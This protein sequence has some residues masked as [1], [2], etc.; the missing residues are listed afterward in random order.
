GKI[1]RHLDRDDMVANTIGTFCSTTVHCAQCHNHKFDPITQ[2]DYYAL[3]A[4]FAAVDRTERKY[5]ADDTLNARFTMLT[6]QQR[7]ADAAIA[8]AEEP[9]RKKA[10]AKFV[11]LTRR[12]DGASKAAAKKLGNTS[13]DYG[14]HSAI[15]PKQDAVKWV[16]V[17]LGRRVPIDHIT[18]LPCYDDFNSIGAGFGFPVRFKVEASDD[19]EFKAGVTL[20]W[21]RHDATF[22]NDFRNPGLQ[23]FTTGGAKDDGIAGRYVRVT[24]VKLAPRKDDFI[25]ALAELQVFDA[26]GTNVAQGKPV[27][28]LDSIE[29]PPRW[30]KAN[31]TDG[32]AP[33][34]QSPDERKQL[35]QER[36]AL[37]AGLA[38]EATTAKRSAMLAESERIA[39]EIKKLP[40]PSVVYAG[41]IHTGSG[42][43]TGT[44]ANG[45]K[46][47]P[48]FLLARGQVTQPGKEMTAG[49]LSA[50]AFAPARFSVAPD[51]PE[52]K[53]RAALARWIT[54]P[55]NPLTWRSIVNR[56][57]QY[58]FGRGLVD[59]P[60]DFG[61]NGALPSHPE[62]LDWLATEFRDSGGSLKKMHKL[63]VMSAAYRQ[64]SVAADVRKRADLP[65]TPNGESARLLTSA[66]TIDT[67]NALLWRQNR[68]KLEAEAVRDSVLAV[69]GK[70]DLTMGGPGWQ[71]FVIEHPE[72]SPHYEYGLANPEDPKTWRRSI[73]R[74]IVRSQTQPWMTSLD[75]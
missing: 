64:S 50:L 68:R 61:R 75:C 54:D 49:T 57:W 35:V 58:H 5:Y 7:D 24:A 16:Q 52:G 53:R 6:R 29:A 46:P 59:T 11:E 44:G 74:F 60:N 27:T 21:Q 70:L 66:A 63:I 62:L 32:I 4:V 56:V 37:L 15:S 69:S 2:D 45:G 13:P 22:M 48:I 41:G 23:P 1:A 31:L 26:D 40:V 51:A 67:N 65:S 12:I 39:A 47:R 19:P 17:D 38:D 72:H 18:L 14:Y 55:Q 10:G 33:V 36:E 73:Y 3:Q 25:F 8:A 42:N 30:R 71:D 34:A 43:F 20:L 28:A 9:L